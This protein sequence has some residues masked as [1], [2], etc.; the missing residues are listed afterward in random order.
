MAMMTSL[1]DITNLY[2]SVMG[3]YEK[4]VNSLNMN[5]HVVR[6]EDIVENFKFEVEEI[7]RFL[8]LQ[9]EDGVMEYQ[10]TAFKRGKINTP[11]YT[12]VIQPIYK[13]SKFAW[14]NYRT[15]FEDV[16]VNLQHWIHKFGY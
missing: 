12:Q 7:V 2:N 13:D 1:D 8:D 4:S 3:I 11:S 5:I 14:E 9:W 6:Y 16:V 10:K 15:N